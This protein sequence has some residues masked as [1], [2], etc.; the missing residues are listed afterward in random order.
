MPLVAALPAIGSLVSAGT[1]LYSMLNSNG[2][3]AYGSTG[4]NPGTYVPTGQAN[5]DQQYQNLI[6]QLYGTASGLPG[7]VSGAAQG[8][9][10]NVA[11]NPYAQSSQ[12]W[13]NGMSALGQQVGQNQVNSGSTLRGWGDQAAGYAPG[14]LNSAL[15]YGNQI[16]QTAMD[17]QQA[18]YDRTSQQTQAQTNA[19]NAMNGVAGTPYGAGL[20]GDSARNFNIDWQNQQL[21]R[22]AT[23]AQAY[24]GLVNGGVGDYNSLMGLG[25]SLYG[26]AG[27]QEN[28]GLNA[29][30]GTGMLPYQTY[31]GQQGDNLSALGSL[32]SLTQG[33]MAPSQSLLGDLGNYLGFGQTAS[34]NAMSGQTSQN[35]QSAATGS[36]FGQTLGGLGSGLSGLAGIFGGSNPVTNYAGYGSTLPSA[37]GFSDLSQALPSFSF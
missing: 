22:Q 33:S 24:S 12:D 37:S 15:G 30:L 27:Q 28:S 2:Q 36:N 4:G 6:Q 35:A 5:A 9:V 20:A 16:M 14:I 25:S 13:A 31:M 19:A 11:N 1:G 3:S 7:Q 17:P 21:N 18:L 8:Y 32:N 23:G 29:M 10:N 34:R 26:Q